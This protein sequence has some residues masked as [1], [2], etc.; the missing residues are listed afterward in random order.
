MVTMDTARTKRRLLEITKAVDTIHRCEE[1]IK[2]GNLHMGGPWLGYM[3]WLEEL[4]RLIHNY[5]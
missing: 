4:H 5:D 3:D 1:E 2:K